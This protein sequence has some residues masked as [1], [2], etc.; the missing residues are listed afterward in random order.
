MVIETFLIVYY[1]T[2]LRYHICIFEN[3]GVVAARSHPKYR[4]G[5]SLKKDFLCGAY[6]R[7]YSKLSDYI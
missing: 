6:L 2:K 5:C 1:S 7:I 3:M 4:R